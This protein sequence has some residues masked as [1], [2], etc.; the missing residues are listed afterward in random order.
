MPQMP[1]T[2]T[3]LG[4]AIPSAL[5]GLIFGFIPSVFTNRSWAM[6]GIWMAD[7]A[8]SARS[9]ALFSSAY[10]LSSC[11]LTR[12]RQKD[13]R[14]T[15]TL[16]GC[17]TGLAIGWGGGPIATLQSAIFIG[18]LSNLMDLGGQPPAANAMDHPCCSKCSHQNQCSQSSDESRPAIAN[19]L[20]TLLPLFSS[21]QGVVKDLPPLSPVM[22]LG[23]MQMAK[24]Y[25]S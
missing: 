14:L 22:W 24:S 18:L 11:I 13:D 4:A 1:C 10:S 8:R 16:S 6:R 17:I 5:I 21:R 3:A 15:R 7:A 9:L 20:A 25:N 2:V 19:P 23:Q 12:V